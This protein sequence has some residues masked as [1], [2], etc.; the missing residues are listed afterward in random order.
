MTDILVASSL[1]TLKDIYSTEHDW[2]KIN[3]FAEATI[4]L[5]SSSYPIMGDLYISFTGIFSVLQEI[6][7]KGSNSQAKSIAIA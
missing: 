4:L 5:S 3:P 7:N 6:I 1:K 2:N